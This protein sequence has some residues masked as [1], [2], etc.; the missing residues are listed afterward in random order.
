[1]EE[2]LTENTVS[3]EQTRTDLEDLKNQFSALEGQT[4]ENGS[5]IGLLSTQLEDVGDELSELI[6]RVIA[7]SY[8]IEELAGDL[9]KAT[10]EIRNSANPVSVSTG[11][12]PTFDRSIPENEANQLFNDCVV[13]RFQSLIGSLYTEALANELPVEDL[14][15]FSDGSLSPV[16]EIALMGAFFGCWTIEALPS[17]DSEL[18]ENEAEQIIYDC[19][20]SRMYGWR[21]RTPEEWE[22][23]DVEIIEKFLKPVP[24][25]NTS[26][27][28]RKE[29]IS[30]WGALLGCWSIDDQ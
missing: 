7:D 11:S 20:W 12:L 2:K 21:E 25:I 18:T 3:V 28:T 17:L 27:L 23:I 29:E 9:E 13:G 16:E 5:A 4:T 10:V 19:L 26:L 30:I 1:M 8:A 6:G 24:E 22:F 14:V 15:G